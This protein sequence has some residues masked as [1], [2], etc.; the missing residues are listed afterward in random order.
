MAKLKNQ[1]T[2]NLSDDYFQELNKAAELLERKPAELAR[3]LLTRQ[4]NELWVDL[5]KQEHPE[6]AKPL[7]KY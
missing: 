4:L 2:V 7:F 3:I 6:N 5:M 1:V